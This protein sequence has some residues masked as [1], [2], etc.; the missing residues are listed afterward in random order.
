MAIRTEIE[1][2]PAPRGECS[3]QFTVDLES[4]R[5][6]TFRK[7]QVLHGVTSMPTMA[8]WLLWQNCVSFYLQSTKLSS[9]LKGVTGRLCLARF[10]GLDTHHGVEMLPKSLLCFDSDGGS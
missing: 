7:S 4:C 9:H 5:N 1:F 2:L 10:L 3:E 6:V 8:A